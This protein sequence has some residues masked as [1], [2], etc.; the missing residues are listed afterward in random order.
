VDT[1]DHDADAHAEAHRARA[2][3]LASA[4][5]CTFDE[6]A[7]T[8][9]ELRVLPP[10]Q[11]GGA[12]AALVVQGLLLPESLVRWLCCARDAGAGAREHRHAATAGESASG[13]RSNV[14]PVCEGVAT[15]LRGAGC[16]LAELAASCPADVVE[17]LLGPLHALELDVHA[18]A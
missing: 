7:R 11:P 17:Q 8:E 2:K 9:A 15:V 6:L 10:R 3:V 13:C 18:A 5:P 4:V 12:P 14:L 16:G 1:D